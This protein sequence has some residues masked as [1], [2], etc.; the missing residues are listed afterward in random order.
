MCILPLQ[1][2]KSISNLEGLSLRVCV[3]VEI[4][5]RKREIRS[6]M[7]VHAEFEELVGIFFQHW[8]RR[9]HFMSLVKLRGIGSGT[10]MPLRARS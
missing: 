1:P 3:C 4:F 9:N 8:F 2:M 6:Y 5:V 7:V 10:W